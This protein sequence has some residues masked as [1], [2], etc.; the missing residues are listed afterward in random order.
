MLLLQSNSKK[1]NIHSLALHHIFFLISVLSIQVY[2]YSISLFKPLLN[3]AWSPAIILDTSGRM[4]RVHTSTLFCCTCVCV[5]AS[6]CLSKVTS[7]NISLNQSINLSINQ[8]I[9]QSLNQSISQSISL[10]INLSINQ[11]LNQSISQSI[12]LSINQ[13]LASGL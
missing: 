13:Y 6:T 7:I 10:S 12:N 3:T 11:Y 5:R 1:Y 8:S 9:N 4:N 2:L